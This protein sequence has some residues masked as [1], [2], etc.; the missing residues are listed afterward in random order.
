MAAN[1]NSYPQKWGLAKTDTNID[2]RRVPNLQAFFSRKGKSLPV[3]D[4]A[5]EYQPG[6]VVTWDLD[7][8]GM[9][10]IGMVSNIWNGSAG[11]YLIIHNIGGGVHA[12]DRLFAWKVTGHFRYF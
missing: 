6:D 11:H 4:I 2:H 9:T 12:E 3:T 5:K 7:G 1:F 10:H 8:R